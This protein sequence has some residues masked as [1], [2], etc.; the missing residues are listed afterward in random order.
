VAEALCGLFESVHGLPPPPC[1]APGVCA[2]WDGCDGGAGL[3][4]RAGHHAVGRAEPAAEIT[5]LLR[6][7]DEGHPRALYTLAALMT[8]GS[9]GT[10]IRKATEGAKAAIVAAAWRYGFCAHVPSF[11][12]F[13]CVCVCVCVPIYQGL[14]HHPPNFNH[15]PPALPVLQRRV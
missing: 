6:L 8:R 14:S 2:C 10:E 11:F 5:L 9:G 7:A 15:D 13:F 1:D 4:G 12:F 3:A